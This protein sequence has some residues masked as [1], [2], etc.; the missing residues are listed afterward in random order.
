MILYFQNGQ[1]ICQVLQMYIVLICPVPH[2]PHFHAP[3]LSSSADT[4]KT[5][6]VECASQ[7]KNAKDK[8]PMPSMPWYVMIYKVKPACICN[9]LP[10]LNIEK[11]TEMNEDNRSH[12][13]SD[14]RIFDIHLI[15]LSR[16]GRC[17]HWEI[18]SASCCKLRRWRTPWV[19]VENSWEFQ[20][21]KKRFHIDFKQN[22][23]D[24]GQSKNTWE[25]KAPESWV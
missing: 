20:N 5:L 22:F 24:N 10:H 14:I 11:A 12:G 18:W 17:C 15:S 25:Y 21:K 4:S 1:V 9:H 13:S 2:L 23:Q 16:R 3:P 8:T 19:S 7:D 6:F